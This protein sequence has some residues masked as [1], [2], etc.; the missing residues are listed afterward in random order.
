VQ[1][2]TR[3]VADPRG[4]PLVGRTPLV[5]VRFRVA[6]K[7]RTVWLKL[8]G[9]NPTGSSKDRAA[10]A[11]LTDLEA[12]GRLAP[13]CTVIESTSGNLGVGLAFMCRERGHPF[14]AVIDPKTTPENRAKMESFGAIV[15]LVQ[16]ADEM[17]GYL[18]S[19]LRRVK[20]L[21]DASTRYVWSDQYGNPAHP[22]CHYR[23]T[24]PEIH[25]RMI[26][27]VPAIFVAVSTGGTLAG[28]G[29][30]FRERS[31][32]TRV[33]A[34]DAH[35]SV[36]FGG[37]P[38]PR[39]LTGIGSARPSSFIRREHY[40]AHTLVTDTEAFAMCRAL[41]RAVGLRVGGSSGAVL[42]ACVEHLLAD[43]QLTEAVCVCPDDGENYRSTIF[44][45]AWLGANG[46]A[47]DRR[48]AGVDGI[49]EGTG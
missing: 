49:Q 21:C 44:D 22:E 38:H 2:D 47:P 24:A 5:S 45:D 7:W 11:L 18:L 46:F 34:V 28:I 48:L 33:V 43:A 6:G 8:E 39:K 40:D 15:D 17:G 26:G 29:R 27:G 25:E 4:V 12:R 30:Y 35:G 14:V 32:A 3:A 20:A 1:V 10:L 41:H 23:T 31:P 19:R 36:V 37:P 42:A 13:G 9:R 16:E